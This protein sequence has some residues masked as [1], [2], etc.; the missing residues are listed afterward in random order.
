[1]NGPVHCS[2]CGDKLPVCDWGIGMCDACRYG[3]PELISH[4]YKSENA[5]VDNLIAMEG[6][7]EAEAKAEVF[8]LKMQ[9]AAR[10]RIRDAEHYKVATAGEALPDKFF[11]EKDIGCINRKSARKSMPKIPYLK[12]KARA[13]PKHEREGRKARIRI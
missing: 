10:K 8:S 13:L 6:S 9:R 1:M 3:G 2:S 11:G 4:P 5:P 12:D 7:V